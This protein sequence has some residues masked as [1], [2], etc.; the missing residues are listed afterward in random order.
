MDIT[1]LN[2]AALISFA[3]GTFSTHVEEIHLSPASNAYIETRLNAF[4]AFGAQANADVWISFVHD[5]DGDHPSQTSDPQTR[6][7]I[8][9]SRGCQL[10]EATLLTEN[11]YA[12]G[13]CLVMSFA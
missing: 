4:S 11:S 12:S 7:H 6:P 8:F 9:S 1:A 3:H 5:A 13:T 2:W 10:V